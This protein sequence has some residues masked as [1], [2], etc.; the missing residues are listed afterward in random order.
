MDKENMFEQKLFL[1]SE[2]GKRLL[3]SYKEKGGT[4]EIHPVNPN[5]LEHFSFRGY[6]S[7]KDGLWYGVPMGKDKDGNYKFRKIIVKGF[8]EFNVEIERDLYEALILMHH[9]KCLK[10]ENQKGKPLFK[11]YDKEKEAEKSIKTFKMEKDC[12]EIALELEGDELVDFSR[13]LGITPES[14]RS[15]VV[16][17]LV[18][19]KAQKSPKSFHDAWNNPNRR[20][21]EIFFRAQ[22]VGLVKFSS[23][24]GWTYK[25]GQML[26]STEEAAIA[27]LN[28][29]KQLLQFINFESLERSDVNTS[30]KTNTPK[31]NVD[32]KTKEVTEV[33]AEKPKQTKRE[34]NQ[35]ANKSDKDNG[36]KSSETIQAKK[37]DEKE[38]SMVKEES[39][40][41]ENKQ[42]SDE[43]VKPELVDEGDGLIG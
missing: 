37:E 29:N 20:T 9:P 21:I 7:R 4:I 31:Y 42:D 22:A 34:E 11:V 32:E 36:G 33:K 18:L 2:K 14:N 25:D 5:R 38:A 30:P 26:G 35:E 39:P 23:D 6:R 10:S 40:K 27:T 12:L 13:M 17:K 19:E 41:P 28:D 3:K 1:E 43:K 15:N 16:K 24:S 8:H